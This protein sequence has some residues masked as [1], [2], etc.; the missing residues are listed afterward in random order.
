MQT[1]KGETTWRIKTGV[2][3]RPGLVDA[4]FAGDGGG[5]DL[6]NLRGVRSG[7]IKKGTATVYP[8]TIDRGSL[9]VR[10]P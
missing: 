2:P 7:A 3:P 10:S 9:G 4:D 6:R 1:A 5:A 8:P